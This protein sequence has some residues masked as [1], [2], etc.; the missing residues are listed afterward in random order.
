MDRTEHSSRT[1]EAQELCSW[2]GETGQADRSPGC[3]GDRVRDFPRLS[4]VSTKLAL[5]EPSEAPGEDWAGAL[6]RLVE[7]MGIAI[8]RAA[9]E[10]QLSLMDRARQVIGS[11]GEA[12]PPIF[13]PWL[14]WSPTAFQGPVA[15]HQWPRARWIASY[16]FDSGTGR[17]GAGTPTDLTLMSPLPAGSEGDGAGVHAMPRM[18]VLKAMIDAAKSEGR[19]KLAIILPEANRNA[20]AAHLVA[21]CDADTRADIEVEILPIEQAVVRI[22]SNEVDW[23]A[24]I[25]MPELRGIVLAMLSAWSGVCAPWPMLWHDRGLS[26]VASEGIGTSARLPLDATLL[27]QGLALAARQGGCGLVADRLHESWAALRDRGLVTPA[28]GSP[29]PYVK[30]VT[31]AEFVDLAVSA[32]PPDGRAL[33]AWRGVACGRSTEAR[34]AGAARLALVTSC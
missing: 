29:A 24:V 23:E 14:C 13:A 22:Q 32:D 7:G 21:A 30:E 16:L 17:P 28:R 15:A 11:T 5:A 4:L 8:E 20:M 33:P 26:M 6:A 9:G 12:G 18:A 31:E 19:R 2:A 10:R 25:A 1:S 27:M 34:R 3:A